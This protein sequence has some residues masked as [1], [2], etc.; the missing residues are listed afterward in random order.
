MKQI[1]LGLVLVAVGAGAGW[2]VGRS[3]GEAAPRSDTGGE[4]RAEAADRVQL[5]D[6]I[7]ANEKEIRRLRKRIQE[8]IEE[9]RRIL[10]RAR[11]PE[12]EPAPETAETP[13]GPPDAKEV[14]AAI[15]GFAGVLQA[16]WA[17]RGGEEQLAR[18]KAVLARGGKPLRDRLIAEF[19]DERTGVQRLV[20]LAHVLGQ[21]AD[22]ESIEA[23]KA[24]L[25]DP[26]AG[27]FHQRYAAHGLAFSPAEGI[28]P[29]LRQVAL[30]AKDTGARAN[31]AF[32]L[33]RRGVDEGVA[34]YAAA[35]DEAFEKGDSLAIAYLSGFALMGE[36]GLPPLRE[37]LLSYEDRPQAVVTMI[38]ILTDAKDEGAV[39][40]LEKLA[41][42]S[43]R[44]MSVRKAALGA[45]EEIK[46]VP[47]GD[48]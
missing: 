43:G 21:S 13:T 31:A 32:G 16:I 23:L 3:S 8:L 48:D 27:D 4:S 34:L 29:F 17:G 40:F 2:Y 44:P 28:E 18:L 6:A 22:P 5:L 20:V 33:A 19:H 14:E 47:H 37:R 38:A 25:R 39:P 46:G 42:D 12:D 41:Y 9:R 10:E 35:T 36:K 1:L 11:A 26:D 30:E 24:M 7:A 45:L 15:G